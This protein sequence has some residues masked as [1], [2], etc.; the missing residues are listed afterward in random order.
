MVKWKTVCEL[1]DV[2]VEMSMGDWGSFSRETI[3]SAIELARASFLDA[4][5]GFM[6][7]QGYGSISGPSRRR[8]LRS[9]DSWNAT[10]ARGIGFL[11]GAGVIGAIW[12]ISVVTP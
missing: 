2:Y 10:T 8:A 1:R 3:D 11:R 9:I 12:I 6:L 4:L 7:G 5:D